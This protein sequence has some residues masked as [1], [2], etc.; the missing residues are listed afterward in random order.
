MSQK[1]PILVADD[2]AVHRQMATEALAGGGFAVTAVDSGLAAIT[3][4]GRHPYAAATL[5]IEMPGMDGIEALRI[6]KSIRPDLPVIMVSG[7][8]TVATAIAAIRQGAYDYIVKPLVPDDLVLSLQRA[9]R[10]R[11]L[12]EENRRLIEDLRSL[13][14][15][16]EELVAQRT[17][18]LERTEQK[19]LQHADDLERAHADLLASHEQLREAYRKLSDLDGLKA[20]FISITSH[21][22][23]TPLTTIYGYA[24]LLAS[25]ELSGARQLGAF[26]A[27]ERNVDRL[28]SIVAEITDIAQL[29]EKRV[30]LRR[31][32]LNAGE[33]TES[34]CAELGPLAQSRGQSIVTEIGEGMPDVL[35]DRIR[36]TQIVQQLIL[37]AIRFTPD[38]GRITVSADSEDGTAPAVCLSV[39]DTGIGIDADQLGLIFEEFYEALPSMNRR[40]GT[41]QFRSGGLGLGLAVVK[42]LIEE[43][44]GSVWAESARSTGGTGSTFRVRLPASD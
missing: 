35:A 28:I 9:L 10:Q 27:L 43:H 26:Q 5:D 21:E 8:S 7:A 2:S 40:S 34:I 6:I 14:E 24:S 19:L 25:G 1:V 4:I 20:K 29:K 42:G 12:T 37:N 30:Y 38:G 18:A 23:R 16:L 15:H 13:N 33:L 36:L 32:K 41:V 22:L 3:E 31:E 39:S 11:E 44:G 17:A